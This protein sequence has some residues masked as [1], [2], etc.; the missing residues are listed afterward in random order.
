MSLNVH[1]PEALLEN[2]KKNDMKM[3]LQ[4][5]Y[6]VNFDYSN[7]VLVQSSYLTVIAC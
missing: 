2:E 7:C 1:P 5:V 3:R 6:H 4:K